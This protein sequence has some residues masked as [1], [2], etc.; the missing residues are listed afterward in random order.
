MSQ[1]RKQNAKSIIPYIKKT[2][3]KMNWE[4]F[5]C[6]HFNQL[7]SKYPKMLKKK[8][9]IFI[10][11]MHALVLLYRAAVPKRIEDF[12]HKAG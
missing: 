7:Y 2:L 3:E 11:T 4:H 10:Y 6:A 5:M 8:L 1:P 9:K 12:I